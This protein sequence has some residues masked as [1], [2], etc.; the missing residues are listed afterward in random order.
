MAI[1]QLGLVGLQTFRP[2]SGHVKPG[3]RHHVPLRKSPLG[4]RRTTEEDEDMCSPAF[5]LG[6]QEALLKT[7]SPVQLFSYRNEEDY[8]THEFF[9]RHSTIILQATDRYQ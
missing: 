5:L 8:M 9:Q 4:Q 2:P 1:T 3:H 6:L 7:F